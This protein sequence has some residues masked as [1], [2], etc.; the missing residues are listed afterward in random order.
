MLNL[1]KVVSG[2]VNQLAGMVELYCI[3]KFYTQK[4][5]WGSAKCVDE[6]G[7]LSLRARLEAKEVG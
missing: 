4:I 3:K 6:G 5:G 7:I 1:S 2:V